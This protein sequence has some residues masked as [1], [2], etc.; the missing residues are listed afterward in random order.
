MNRALALTALCAVVVANLCG[1]HETPT[2]WRDA[3]I[4]KVSKE[5][6]VVRYQIQAGLGGDDAKERLL[7]ERTGQP[8]R[9]L[10][11]PR[12]AGSPSPP[13]FAWNPTDRTLS[14]INCGQIAQIRSTWGFEGTEVRFDEKSMS[15]SILKIAGTAR[16]E[17]PQS[18][19]RDVMRWFC[20]AA[21]AEAYAKSHPAS[22]TILLNF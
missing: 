2:E 13:L 11:S 4:C 10:V 6:L 5:G 12:Y 3:A 7:W 15:D 9:I 18:V 16:I 19:Q 20:S 22:A 17:L 8:R 14:V 21:G 1:C